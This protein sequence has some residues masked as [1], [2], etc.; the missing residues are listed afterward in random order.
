MKRI[1]CLLLIS[2]FCLTTEAVQAQKKDNSRYWSK[3]ALVW[4]DFDGNSQGRPGASDLACFFDCM[5]VVDTIGGARVN[6][7]TIRCGMDRNASWVN[8]RSRQELAYNQVLFDLGELVCCDM[9]PLLKNASLASSAPDD[10]VL[11][12]QAE[13]AKFDAV[14]RGGSNDSIVKVWHDSV[15]SEIA[16]RHAEPFNPSF[17]K[18][19]GVGFEIGL[20]SAVY[21]GDFGDVA[22]PGLTLNFDIY[23]AYSRSTFGFSVQTGFLH[24]R[25]PVYGTYGDV[26][27]VFISGYP[28]DLQSQCFRYGFAAIEK[29]SFRMMP[30]VGIGHASVSVSDRYLLRS[31]NNNG[32]TLQFGSAFDW[33]FKSWSDLTVRDPSSLEYHLRGSVFATYYDISDMRGWGINFAVSLGWM[34]QKGR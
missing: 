32:L 17:K 25:K 20:G 8:T 1:I 7:Y 33:R 14:S 16:R 11:L 29:P 28:L 6:H 22:K 21:L 15:R 18:G 5:P 9:R 4:G 34:A 24:T 3:S 27:T 19:L 13:V 12:W 2:L 23:V 10:A 30:F 26:Q 31:F